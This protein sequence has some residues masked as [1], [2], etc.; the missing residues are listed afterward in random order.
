MPVDHFL[1]FFFLSYNISIIKEKSNKERWSQMG[2]IVD[3][4]E[5]INDLR[6]DRTLQGINSLDDIKS[7][8]FR[9]NSISRMSK[10]AVAQF[11]SLT[12][13]SISL[14]SLTM[15]NK[16]LERNY[17]T[18]IR[19]AMGLDD[20]Y[21][22]NMSK[23]EVLKKF[24]QNNTFSNFGDIAMASRE[25]LKEHSDDL[26]MT[27]L[28]DMTNKNNR[29]HY[30][31][32]IR[33]EEGLGV[34]LVTKNGLDK[35]GKPEPRI[36]QNDIGKVLLD[37]SKQLVD[38][39]VKKANE[40]MPTTVNMRVFFKGESGTIATDILFGVKVVSHPVSSE[41]M[42]YNTAKSVQEK[43]SF[44]KTIQ[45]TTG[46][47]KFFKDY[48]FALDRI[49]TEAV[50]SRRN[51]P[52]WRHLKQRSLVSRL[53][54]ATFSKNELL[55]NTT[56][57]MSMDEVEQIISSFGIDFMSNIQAVKSLID[58]F[59]LLGFVIVDEGSEIVH[60]YFHGEDTY[61]SYSFG[62][63]E[64]ENKNSTNELKSIVSVMN[65]MR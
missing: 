18:M 4:I 44:F 60:F 5:I 11:P 40:L 9:Q 1:I 50:S 30:A 22:G 21:D 48:V 12:T 34:S 37:P 57:I 65:R 35:D 64:R 47:I 27:S 17:A 39:D 8:N 59:F 14:D 41:E 24:H 29:N 10:Q 15:V 16:A 43:R 49:K 6:K 52:W 32:G 19:L 62:Q 45:W 2:A 54:K 46:E 7:G 28:N 55:P 31:L 53:K 42:V 13:R 56:I 38:N 51:S 61:Q 63:L 25:L 3:I 26:R 58:V 23:S 20:I 36:T 33:N